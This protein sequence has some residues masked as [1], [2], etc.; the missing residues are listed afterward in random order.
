MQVRA[1]APTSNT[2]ILCLANQLFLFI[3]LYQDRFDV[4][5]RYVEKVV[6]P[7]F[8]EREWA[9]IEVFPS[10]HYLGDVS[11]E[12]F[13]RVHQIITGIIAKIRRVLYIKP[14]FPKWLALSF[15]YF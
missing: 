11:L 12:E 10:C 15:N 13:V 8:P 1:V 7:K 3:E 2:N 14:V 6:Q 9:A 4:R 5:C